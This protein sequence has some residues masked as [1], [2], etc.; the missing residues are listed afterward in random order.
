[1]KPFLIITGMHRSGTSF[2]ARALNLCGVYLGELENLTSHELAPFEDNLR[3]H[4][5]NKKILELTEKTLNYNKLSWHDIPTNMK[6]TDDIG[7]EIKECATELLKHNWLA[8]GFKDPRILLMLDSWTPFLPKNFIVLGIFRHPLKV[9]E[10][11]KKR[12]S[13]DYEKSLNLW[14]FHN[15]KL[16]F[17]LKKHDGFLLNFDWPKEKL[18][19]E[20]QLIAEKIGLLKDIDLTNWYA[21]E[22][23]HSDKT[24]ES[25][26]PLADEFNSIYNSLIKIAENNKN[27]KVSKIIYAKNDYVNFLTNLLSDIQNQNQYFKSLLENNPLVKIKD[28]ELSNLKSTLNSKEVDMKQLQE[29]LKKAIMDVKKLQQINLT[30]QEIIKSVQKKDSKLLTLE[31][32]LTQKDSKLSD[33]ESTLETRDTELSNLKSTLETRDTELS[34]LKLFLKDKENHISSL[35]KSLTETQNHLLQIHQSLTFRMLRKYDNSFGKILPIKTKTLP[36]IKKRRLFDQSDQIKKEVLEIPVSKK[37][38]IY[39]PIINWDYR[40]QRPQH[41]LKQFAKNGHRVFYFTISLETLPESYLIKKID[42][43]IFQIEVSSPQ[44]FNIY[45][46]KFDDQ[47]SESIVNNLKWLIDELLIDPICFVAFPTWQPITSKLSDLYGY[48][49]IF[50]CLDDFNE[51]PNVHHSRKMEEQLLFQT[52]DLVLT[53]SHALFEK[54]KQKSENVIFLPNAGEFNHFSKS[55]Q[56]TVLNEIK[57]PIVGYFGSIAEWFDLELLKYLAENRPDVNFVLIGHTYGANIRKVDELD[58]VYFLGEQP[59]ADLPNY[60]HSFDVCIIPF[61]ITPLTRATNPVKIFEYFAAGKPVVSTN[62]PEL[63]TIKELCYLAENKT[64]FLKK[65]DEAL[66]EDDKELIKK[67]IE[68]ASKNTWIDRFKTLYQKL[69]KIESLDLLQHSYNKSIIPN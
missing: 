40:Y 21:K 9:A 60:L 47:L 30:N 34:N 2:L 17:Y 14:K 56:N 15:E 24:F 32:L 46:D 63:F 50:D 6:I 52:S 27:V 38:I 64:D 37:D 45:S 29:S 53:T 26:H 61:K 49:I 67:R 12:N 4:W 22:L 36:S 33:L 3:G 25:N 23:F 57:K 66:N 10:S 5:E 19:S 44:H 69:D 35:Q 1:M 20:V 43:N 13:F 65:L 39:F 41:I 11:L 7:N 62:L 55:K 42:E 59:Y 28:S 68:F 58:N 54:A 48:K 31:S 8:A 18:L 51:F 16:I